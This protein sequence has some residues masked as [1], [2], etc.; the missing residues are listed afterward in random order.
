MKRHWFRYASAS[1]V[2]DRHIGASASICT[3]EPFDFI[4]KGEITT[5]A[6]NSIDDLFY[7][8]G[9]ATV[10]K[11]AY[12]GGVA[13]VRGSFQCEIKAE[14]KSL[15][16]ILDIKDLKSQMP[17]RNWQ[18][19]SPTSYYGA[20]AM[21]A[22]TVS[23]SSEGL[24]LKCFASDP[25]KVVKDDTYVVITRRQLDGLSTTKVIGHYEN[26]IPTLKKMDISFRDSFRA[27]REK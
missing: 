27:F 10:E 21:V 12:R 18:V 19:T 5:E 11:V 6:Q 25:N 3:P 20:Y 8:W 24:V 23:M 15:A 2:A 4:T 26:P 7:G 16:D 9:S 13:H 17:K 22:L 14:Q 1:K